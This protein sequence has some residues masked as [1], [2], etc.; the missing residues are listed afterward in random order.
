MSLL[1]TEAIQVNREGS[2]GDFVDGHRV[3]A[4]D[5]VFKGEGSIQPLN[6][7]EILQLPE[8]DRIRQVVKVYTSLFME[9]ND[10]MT[11]LSDNAEFEIQRSENWNV[12]NMLQHYKAIAFLQDAQ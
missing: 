9:T 7:K 1:R 8:S 2:G 6:G 4:A 5:D 12:F 10:K 11:R 3:S